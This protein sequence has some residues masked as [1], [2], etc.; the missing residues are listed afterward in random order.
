MSNAPGAPVVERLEETIVA[1]LL[2][3]YAAA[4]PLPE[5]GSS[6]RPWLFLLSAWLVFA[7]EI[8]AL[9]TV[10]RS[11]PKSDGSPPALLRE[12]PFLVGLL[13]VLLPAKRMLTV[14]RLAGLAERR[15]AFRGAL[16]GTLAAVALALAGLVLLAEVESSENP[17]DRAERLSRRRS[18]A[19]AAILAAA[20]AALLPRF[21]G[22]V[23]ALWFLLPPFL[24]AERRRLR[25]VRVSADEPG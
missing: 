4:L 19:L 1:V 22:V 17:G 6:L 11:L 5:P 16:A 21:G 2:V 9:W 23:L 15:D 3:L 25:R 12:L 18:I 10:R 13:A 8:G 7:L 14:E 20:S 24:A